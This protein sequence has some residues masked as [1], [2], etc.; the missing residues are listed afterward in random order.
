MKQLTTLILSLVGGFVLGGLTT[1]LV[2][3]LIVVATTGQ[4]MPRWVLY[5][6]RVLG[7]LAVALILFQIMGGGGG[8]G[9][10]GGPGG[11]GDGTGTGTADKDST[12]ARQTK[13]TPKEKNVPTE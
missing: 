5:L 4:K 1:G 10:F 11:A 12:A 9:G 8:G 2:V 3:R 6:I 7:G 13:E